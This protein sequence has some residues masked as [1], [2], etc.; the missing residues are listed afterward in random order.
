MKTQIFKLKIQKN[1]FIILL[2]FFGS[3]IHL[4]AQ[5]TSSHLVYANCYQKVQFPTN[6]LNN[7]FKFLNT[8]G[9][10]KIFLNLI[11]PPAN[12]SWHIYGRKYNQ[13]GFID[14]LGN[15]NNF[16]C[17][18]L[19]NQGGLN[20]QTIWDPNNAEIDV[21]YESVI[22]VPSINGEAAGNYP[23]TQIDFVD[24]EF[25]IN[26][27]YGLPKC[28]TFDNFNFNFTHNLVG[29][30]KIPYFKLKLPPG[31]INNYGLP[32]NYSLNLFQNNSYQIPIDQNFCAG[33]VACQN[34]NGNTIGCCIGFEV[35]I[36]I[37]PCLETSFEPIGPDNFCP[38]LIF[39]K[40]LNIC[41]FCGESNGSNN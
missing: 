8:E 5:P 15:F 18:R 41:C 32:S 19:I 40:P 3:L 21:M 28:L 22:I 23:I 31:S 9:G 24:F 29:L 26:S 20:E 27:N 12:F 36:T 16:G 4:K 34:S 35:E 6:S 2:I 30:C 7:N 14:F 39:K 17:C 10:R 13:S 11:D 1:S 25:E 38:P 33:N 37:T